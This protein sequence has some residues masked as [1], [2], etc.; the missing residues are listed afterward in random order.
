MHQHGNFYWKNAKTLLGK[1]IKFMLFLMEVTVLMHRACRCC[2]VRL[3]AGELC[4]SVVGKPIWLVQSALYSQ[5]SKQAGC[6]H[7]A[8]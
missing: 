7:Q 1:E 3:Y 8:A 4:S 2:V 6:V 5:P